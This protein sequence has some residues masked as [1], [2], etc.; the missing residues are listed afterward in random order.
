MDRDLARVWGPVR[1]ESMRAA[2]A[3][4]GA[5]NATEA[6]ARAA[7]ALDA[8]A[9][10][11]VAARREACEATHVHGDQSGELLDLRVTCLHRRLASL[12]ALVDVFVD[13]PTDVV[14][15]NAVRATSRLDGLTGCADAEAL[16]SVI[17]PP[18]DAATRVAVEGIRQRIA[19]ATAIG[20]T[21][22][23]VK[24][25]PVSLETVEEAKSLAYAPLL[26]EA[27]H[28]LALIESYVGD[29]PASEA[30][31][32]AALLA[33]S[34]A[35]DDHLVARVYTD[36]LY[37]IGDLQGR[38]A[39]AL[40]LR[41]AAE[42]AFRRTNGDAELEANLYT[43]F[44]R[45]LWAAGQYEESVTTFERAL[46]IT[47]QASGKH[48]SAVAR[49]LTGL[50]NV[51][52]DLE[53][54]DEALLHHERALAI[55][56]AMHGPDHADV[57]VAQANIA[58]VYQNKGDHVGAVARYEAVR[59]G[60]S[61]SL[62][63]DNVMVASA[64]LNLGNS[65]SALGRYDEAITNLERAIQI[66][67]KALG[68]AHTDIALSLMG[69]GKVYYRSD[70]YPQSIANYRKAIEIYEANGQGESVLIAAPLSGLA[71][72]LRLTRAFDEAL[73]V[74]ERTVKI[75]EATESTA[76]EVA[77]AR[78]NLGH[79]LLDAGRQRERARRLVS[80]ARA[81]LLAA[82]DAGNAH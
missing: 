70:R 32:R 4:S 10:S 9:A 71:E 42:A 57:I 15:K 17:P 59:D 14:V 27:L 65:L 45:T 44:G 6:S 40:A 28:R 18:A 49:I 36:L 13:A 11:W 66:Q 62:G 61:R 72:S 73:A 38:P 67:V 51:L 25:H 64:L 12:D 26:A 24:A 41:V 76:A 34:D 82:G 46:R 37:T 8:Y 53:R 75:R 63:A 39:E 56:S 52:Q 33:A 31:L 77:S 23:F 47:E 81:A 48:S 29:L 43:A 2:F 55:W 79:T 21:G 30:T 22:Q 19:A 1:A 5:P 78:M 16:R 54:Y 74:A 68:P 50:A 60:F 35:H 3:K 80:D 58:N 69:L 7:T 20:R